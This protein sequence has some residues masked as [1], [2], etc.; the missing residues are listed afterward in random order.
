[1][2][3]LMFIFIITLVVFALALLEREKQRQEEVDRLTGSREELKSLLTDLEDR[4]RHRGI[5]VRIVPDQGVLRLGERLLFASGSAKLEEQGQ[6]TVSV[7]ASILAD[8]LPCYTGAGSSSASL[9]CKGRGTRGR[10]DALFI[11]GHTDD[12]R[13]RASTG[14][15]DNWYLSVARAKRVYEGLTE[16]SASLDLLVN[17]EHQ[18]ILSLSGYA[19]RRAVEPNTSDELRAFNR[20]ID[21]RFVMAPPRGALPEPA[22][23][24]GEALGR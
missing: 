8:V 6:E 3:G 16:E 22:R 18:P 14:F 17:E 7:L 19:E 5:E 21:L 4:L 23:R 9:R 12:R 1:M 20:R 10:V 11:E 2:S 15:A 24:T 13:P